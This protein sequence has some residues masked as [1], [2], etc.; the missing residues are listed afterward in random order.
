MVATFGAFMT[1][2]DGSV[3]T[4]ALPSIGRDLGGSVVS[5]GWIATGYVLGLTICVIPFGRLA[6]IR[7]RG[8]VYALGVSLFTIA[9]ALCGLAPSLAVLIATRILQGIAAAM[10][11]GNSIAL[12]TSVFPA[13]ERGKVLGIN[14]AT[15]YI[16]LSVGPSLGGFMVEHLGWRSVFYV[17]VPIGIIVVALAL[18][19]L[20]REKTEARG[21]KLDPAGIVTWGLALSMILLGLTLSETQGS[22]LSRSL[23]I[24]G[25]AALVLFFFLER[26]VRSPLLDLKLFSNT[27]FTFSALTALLNYSSVFG[28]SFVLSLYLQIISGFDAEQAGMIML[29]QPVLMAAL[30]PLGGRLSDKIEP[31]IIA[32]IGMA[33]VAASIFS[34]SLLPPHAHWWDVALRLMF[35][36]IGHAFFSSPNTNA[37]MSSVE[38]RQYGVAAAVLSTMRFTGQAISLAV[39]TSIL[40]AKLGGMAISGSGAAAVPETAFMSGMKVALVLLSVICAAGVFTSLVRGTVRTGQSPSASPAR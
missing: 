21:E 5:L 38:R 26:R 25:F 29:V 31:R 14:T 11:A 3:V 27:P 23:L 37:T 20:P 30:S 12:L 7:G 19:K 17:N 18:T 1:P 40:S 15:V 8:R 22:T 2:F 24:S 9:S 39:A 33:I 6:D 35:L 13:N 16:G 10:M 28:V 4:L 34:L 32:S 36:G